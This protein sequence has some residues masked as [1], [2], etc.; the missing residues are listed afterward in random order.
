MHPRTF[1]DDSESGYLSRPQQFVA[2]SFEPMRRCL[3]ARLG[4]Y[5]KRVM[6]ATLLAF[7]EPEGFQEYVRRVVLALEQVP[8]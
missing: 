1:N 6:P 7:T 8:A 3:F 5:G 2:R 4:H